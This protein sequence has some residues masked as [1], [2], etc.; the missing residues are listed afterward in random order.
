MFEGGTIRAPL[1]PRRTHSERYFKISAINSI[2]DAARNSGVS[3]Y[4][5]V[6][7]KAALIPAKHGVMNSPVLIKAVSIVFL[8]AAARDVCMYINGSNKYQPF[9][10]VSPPCYRILIFHHGSSKL[11]HSD[12]FTN[13]RWTPYDSA[14]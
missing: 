7:F 4:T 1:D 8:S 5:A 2:L 13:R 14:E 11:E 12:K 9:G 10:G 6:P 3:L